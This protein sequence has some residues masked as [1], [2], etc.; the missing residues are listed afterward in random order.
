MA[1]KEA[2]VKD[3]YVSVNRIRWSPDGSIFGVAYAK[4]IVQLYSYNGGYNNWIL[5][6]TWEV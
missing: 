5:M 2:L 3:S 4:H 6:L 1:L